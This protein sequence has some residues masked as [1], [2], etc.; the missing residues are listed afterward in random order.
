MLQ[1]C[2]A[3][4]ERLERGWSEAQRNSRLRE[5]KREQRQLKAELAAAK[6]RL[7]VPTGRWSYER[8]YVDFLTHLN[9]L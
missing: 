5:L 1:Y 7:L 3:D 9:L 4:V 8:E 2:R 6:S